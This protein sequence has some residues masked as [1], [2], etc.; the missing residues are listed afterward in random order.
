M[1]PGLTITADW[2]HLEEGTP[3]ERACFSA[4]GIYFD[5][6]CLSE[7]RDGF[8]NR[9]RTEPL[10]SA[11][12]L[13][14][15]LAWNWWRL[16]WE[17]RSNA[18]D[19]AF[20]HRMA[21]IG[22]GYVWPNITIVS[23]GERTGLIAKPS[24]DGSASTFRYINDVSAVMPSFAFETAVDLFI[25]QVIGQL[26]AERIP[27]TNLDKIWSELGEERR[28]RDAAQ[29]RKLEA[30]L[31][32]DPDQ[33]DPAVLDRL[34]NDAQVLGNRS[35]E[36]LAADRA[37]GG[38]LLT[39]EELRL[40]AASEGFAVSPGAAATLQAGVFSPEKETPPWKLGAN[41]A[42]ALRE[43]E[44]FGQ[45]PIRD[46]RLA[47]MAGVDVDVLAA[48]KRGAGLSFLLDG[49]EG[50]SRIVLR[51][52]WPSGRRFELARLLGDRIVSPFGGWLH[53]AT[54]AYTYRQKV[55]RSFAAELL[56]PFEA[57]DGMLAGDYSAEAQQDVA[58]HFGVSDLTIRTLL[59]AHRRMGREELEEDVGVA[60]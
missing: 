7:G 34:L 42:R 14:E 39:G 2:E 16:R 1:Q 19:W 35:V 9:I 6:H 23:D 49:P 30:L 18:P 36:E 48:G 8:V 58:E 55:Q 37:Q 27:E 3:E 54:R 60:A 44:G 21:T 50:D 57:V 41:A 24:V 10:L 32:C 33:A 53:P 40:I 46:A 13:A 12:H 31:G 29:R 22:E 52:A 51:S 43:Q 56:S 26:R 28:D 59:V 5:N 15:W 38:D 45:E 4:V 25:G 47:D 17:P 20:A 11:Y